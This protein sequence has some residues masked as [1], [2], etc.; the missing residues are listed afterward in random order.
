MPENILLVTQ[1]AVKTQVIESARLGP[2]RKRRMA[3][4]A[5]EAAICCSLH[6]PNVVSAYSYELKPLAVLPPA[7]C[8]GAARAAVDGGLWK[9]Y[10]I[11]EFCA[12]GA[13]WLQ[14]CAVAHAVSAVVQVACPDCVHAARS[15]LLTPNYI[16][17]TLTCYSNDCGNSLLSGTDV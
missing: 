1:V 15:P 3:M 7:A 8:G 5:R 10:I 13:I 9:L 14:A 6:H 2:D 16:L 12:L 4:A 17:L 11:Q